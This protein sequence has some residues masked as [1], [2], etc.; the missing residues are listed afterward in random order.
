MMIRPIDGNSDAATVNAARELL[1]EYGRFVLAAK[2]PAQ[3]CFGALEDEASG[4]PGSYQA[5]GGELLLAL[6]DG[7]AAGC[8][9]YRAMKNRPG[10]CEMKRLWVRSAFRGQGLGE[11]LTLEVLER[12]RAAGY[13]TAYLDTV[14]EKMGSAYRM[15]LHLGFTLCDRFNDSAIEGIVYMQRDLQQDRHRAATTVDDA[16]KLTPPNSVFVTNDL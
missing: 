1:L 12:A 10:G 16:S 8:V 9:G 13:S 4:L 2:G 14:P 7:E 5:Q 15:Y 3:F 11:R 6:V